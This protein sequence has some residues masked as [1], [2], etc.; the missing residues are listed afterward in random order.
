MSKNGRGRPLTSIKGFIDRIDG[1]SVGADEHLFFRGHSNRDKYYIEP[2]VFRKSDDGTYKGKFEP[3]RHDHKAFLE[4]ASM[5]RGFDEAYG[6]LEVEYALAHEM[7]AARAR[8]GLAQEA[9]ASRMGTTNNA[10]SR[11]EL[12]GKHAPSVASLKQMRP[13]S[14]ARSRSNW[15]P[16]P[17]SGERLPSPSDN[18]MPDDK[19]RSVFRCSRD[20]CRGLRD[21]EGKFH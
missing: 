16:L 15:F 1:L 19:P 13:Q 9:V 8:A 6:A 7:L 11:L 18:R 5:R 10:I 2:S 4:K 3:V 17:P 21:M 12:A 14:A 20:G